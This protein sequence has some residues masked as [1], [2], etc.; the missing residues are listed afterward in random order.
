M[1][2]VTAFSNPARQ[3]LVA[4]LVPREHLGNAMSLNNVMW[5]LA[6]IGGPALA[7]AILGKFGA[8]G[9][10][11]IYAFNAVSFSFML[12][13]LFAMSYRGEDRDVRS[14][15]HWNSMIEGLRFTYDSR[16]IWGS[17]MLDFVATFF[18]SA[19]TML[20][21]V[22]DSILKSGAE[23]FGY[24]ST[25]QSVGAVIT[26]AVL[27]VRTDIKK[28]GV[29]LLASVAVYGLAT[30]LFGM[31]GW[32]A[33]SYFLLAVTGAADTVSTV[34]RSTLRN[35]I[36]PDYLRGRM[37]GINMIFFTG[38]PQLGELEAG[39]VASVLGVPFAII[40]GG[41]ATVALTLYIAWKYPTLR[42]YSTDP[43]KQVVRAQP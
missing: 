15:L 21:I 17:M 1:A 40:S 23:G 31:T 19:R 34:I 18:A 37:T 22:A 6:T 20:P 43:E 24:L 35:L 27:S 38:G 16:I 8:Q 42:E 13:A 30:A 39:L 4:N 2:A 41:I 29:I 26:A 33:L 28:E 5:Q 7:G 25:A 9:P 10:G 36:T 11:I 32:F 12:V 14:G 3:A